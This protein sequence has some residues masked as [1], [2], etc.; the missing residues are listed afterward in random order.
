[1]TKNP[2]YVLS[3]DIEVPG[4]GE[5]IGSG[6]RVFDPK[7]LIERLKEQGLKEEEYKEYIDLRRYGHSQ[8][9]GMGLGFDRVMTWLLGEFNIRDIV[10]FPRCPGRLF[11]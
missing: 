11:Q 5:V 10:T 2:S 3:C 8:T 4:V 7:E 9:S 1:M 6:I